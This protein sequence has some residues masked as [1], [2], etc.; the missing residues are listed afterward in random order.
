M[1][2]VCA[3]FLHDVIVINNIEEH[4]MDNIIGK[5]TQEEID[6]Y[7]DWKIERQL[8]L[9]DK[10]NGRKFALVEKTWDG[11]EQFCSER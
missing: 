2:D 4:I 8:D 3:G 10:I 7:R 5:A 9:E 1:F 6:E 11:C